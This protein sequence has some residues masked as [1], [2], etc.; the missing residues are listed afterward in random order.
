MKLKMDTPMASAPIVA[1]ELSRCPATAELTMPI[2][3]TVM[4]EMMFGTANRRISRFMSWF[5]MCKYTAFADKG[6]YF[7]TVFRS[8]SRRDNPLFG[9]SGCRCRYPENRLPL[10]P[11]PVFSAGA[12]AG[13]FPVMQGKSSEIADLGPGVVKRRSVS[14]AG[15]IDD[16]DFR[17]YDLLNSQNSQNRL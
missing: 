13:V 4:L 8:D 3:G 17:E 7:G 2:R 16:C 6:K 12:N 11:A 9:N 14:F 1:A 5:L 15:S 10:L